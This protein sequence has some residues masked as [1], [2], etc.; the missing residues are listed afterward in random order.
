MT[1]GKVKRL[2]VWLHSA[3]DRVGMAG[4]AASRDPSPK[5]AGKGTLREEQR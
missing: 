2:V 3:R 5:E 1:R 4:R